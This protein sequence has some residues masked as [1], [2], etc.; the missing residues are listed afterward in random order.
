MDKNELINRFGGE[1][2]LSIE[3]RL[4]QW[5]H[6]FTRT[7]LTVYV[8]WAQ[9]HGHL[10]RLRFTMLRAQSTKFTSKLID[11][12]LYWHFFRYRCRCWTHSIKWPVVQRVHVDVDVA[13]ARVLRTWCVDGAR[14]R[15]ANCMLLQFLHR[16]EARAEHMGNG[17]TASIA[18]INNKLL[19]FGR[20]HWRWQL[21]AFMDV[22]A[23]LIIVIQSIWW[24][25]QP[26]TLKNL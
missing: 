12:N 17:R 6:P 9:R 11:F 2:A 22:H 21:K 16:F 13:V 26:I 3:D 14:T 25:N 7:H 1:Y 5:W 15:N 19:C 4:W 10:E 24:P 20:I 23:D 18:Q 8:R